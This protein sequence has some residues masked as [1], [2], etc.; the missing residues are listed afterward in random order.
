MPVFDY[1]CN[2]GEVK[3]D[4][5]VKNYKEVVLCECGEEMVRAASAP[6]LGNMNELG[7]TKT[8]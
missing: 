2:C 5:L 4:K 6:N 1:T 8:D 7:Q 3:L